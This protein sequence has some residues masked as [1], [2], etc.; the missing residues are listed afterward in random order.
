MSSTSI[1][2]FKPTYLYIKQHTIT[3]K[4]YFGKTSKPWPWVESYLGSGHHW[5]RHINKHGIE[6]VIT[7]WYCLFLD[8]DSITEF[9]LM[10]SKNWDIVN[11]KEWLNL[12]E[13]NGLDGGTTGYA[14]PGTISA[15]DSNGNIFL[16]K[17]DDPKWVS[18]ELIG[19]MNGHKHNDEVC[20]N[21][22]K[23]GTKYLIH[24]PDSTF[25]SWREAVKVTGLSR[26][27]LT[28]LTEEP[29]KPIT[30]Y[31]IEKYNLPKDWSNKL[32][33]E[34]GFW[35]EQKNTYRSNQN[36]SKHQSL[37]HRIINSRENTQVFINTPSGR[38]DS[39]LEASLKSNL[40]IIS[41][42]YLCNTKK[43]HPRSIK[44]YGLP[45]EWVWKLTSELGYWKE[46]K[47]TFKPSPKKGIPKSQ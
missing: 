3:G 35:L 2:T 45:P 40:P 44:T 33:I 42:K 31:A 39:W 11:S 10:C 41:L 9:A 25:D 5:L 4:L 15:K 24:T 18:G 21:H 8:K 17:K 46:P 7:L 26:D 32:R 23:S 14:K 30:E 22:S 6:H 12:S 36:R 19:I 47:P 43:V 27:A 13:E 29:S 38:F 28:Y 34:I 20:I 1:Y 37:E 16:V